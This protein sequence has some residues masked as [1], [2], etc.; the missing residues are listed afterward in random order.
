MF[1]VF[2]KKEEC[3][4]CTACKSICPTKAI[5]MKTDNEGFK[6]PEINQKLCIDCGLCRKTCA[7]QNGYDISENFE[8]PDAYGVKHKNHEIRMES[9]SGGMFTAISDYILENDGVVYGVGYKNHF[10]VCHKRAID[11][12]QRDEFRGSKYVQS[13]LNDV[14]LQVRNDLLEDKWVMFTGTPCQTAGLDIYLTRTGINKDKFILCDIICHG[15]PSPKLFKDY[16]SY[17][18]QKYKNKIENFDFRNKKKFGWEA[19]RESF[20]INNKEYYSDIYTTLFYKH[21]SLRPSCFNCKYT[22]MN[23]PSDITLADFWGIDKIS[24]DFNDNRGVSLV[25][26]NTEKGKKI[27]NNVKNKLDYLNCTGVSFIHPNLR[28]PTKRPASREQFWKDYQ[29]YGFE[30]IVKEYAEY[31]FKGIM[32]RY[33]L[34]LVK[35]IGLYNIIRKILKR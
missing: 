20:K 27:F 21:D 22:N 10:E 26:V 5:D 14:F 17:I 1:S 16:I 23:R 3:C 2:D 8:I 6:Y 29:K 15:T 35:K 9:R 28:E 11:R 30:Y 25:F 12:S 13:E 18:E 24:P 7:F 32:K 31:N 4:G 33:T 34:A 19:H